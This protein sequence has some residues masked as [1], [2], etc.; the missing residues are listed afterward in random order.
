MIHVDA[1]THRS[2]PLLTNLFQKIC[3]VLCIAPSPFVCLFSDLPV[4]LPYSFFDL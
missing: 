1:V 2:G 3:L 4:L